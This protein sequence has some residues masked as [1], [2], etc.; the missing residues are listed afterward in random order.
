MSLDKIPA[1]YG[2]R[3]NS[4][5]WTVEM[6]RE[7]FPGIDWME[8]MSVWPLRAL[9]AAGCHPDQWPGMA[10]R[11]CIARHGLAG[12][13]IGKLPKTR[14]EFDHH[15]RECHPEVLAEITPVK[16]H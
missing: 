3:F 15:M 2:G 12:K 13:N 16:I 11:I 9:A 7:R 1:P 5:P 10:C 8:P 14:E 4:Q 6:L